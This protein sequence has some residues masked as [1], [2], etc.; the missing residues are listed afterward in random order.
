[1]GFFSSPYFG[2]VGTVNAPT[3]NNSSTVVDS[4][5]ASAQDIS[6]GYVTVTTVPAPSDG[7]TTYTLEIRLTGL[8]A[9]HSLYTSETHDGTAYEDGPKANGLTTDIVQM[10]IRTSAD[11]GSV[12]VRIKD[13]A[14]LS[15]AASWT[16]VLYEDALARIRATATTVSSPV[17]VSDENRLTLYQG[18]SHESGDRLPEWSFED[19]A[20]PSLSGATA[21]LR[22]LNVADYE[23]TGT[24]AEAELQVSA[25]ISVSGSIVDVSAPITAVQTAELATFPPLDR[26]THQYHLVATT[27]GGK[28]VTLAQGPVTVYREVPTPS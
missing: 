13:G 22:L 8:H 20:G 2:A 25:T 26:T 11:E 27:S 14:G 1:M 17:D 5:S 10:T 4:G 16:W 19:Y 6:G 21:V 12:L 18:D 23:K 28:K 7:A 15:T 9:S 3:G 24:N